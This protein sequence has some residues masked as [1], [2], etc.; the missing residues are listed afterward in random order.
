MVRQAGR[1]PMSTV[2]EGADA[3][4]NLAVS[5]EMSE[6]TGE[7]FDRLSPARARAQAYDRRSRERLRQISFELTGY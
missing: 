3:I 7:Y 6:R 1:A 4:M 5:D 2:D